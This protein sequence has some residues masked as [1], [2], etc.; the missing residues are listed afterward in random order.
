MK[1]IKYIDTRHSDQVLSNFGITLAL[2]QILFI[3]AFSIFVRMDT[4]TDSMDQERAPALV[5]SHAMLLVGFSYLMT[6]IKQTNLSVLT[7][8][9]LVSALVMQLYVLL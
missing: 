1:N 4:E 7:Y 9:L 8:S 2:L 5:G 3:I 6:S